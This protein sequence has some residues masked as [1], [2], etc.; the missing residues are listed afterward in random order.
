MDSF[1]LIVGRIPS[2]KYSGNQAQ[3]RRK[4]VKGD[5]DFKLP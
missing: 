4:A 2:T 3:L 1:T 5:F